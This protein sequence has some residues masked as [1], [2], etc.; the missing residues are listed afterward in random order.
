MT[1]LRKLAVLPPARMKG[2]NVETALKERRVIVADNVK[3]LGGFMER[4]LGLRQLWNTA[5]EKEI[6]F[7]GEDKQHP[8]FLRPELYRPGKHPNGTDQPLKP[9]PELLR[10]ENDLY[11]EFQRC[12]VQ[13]RTESA[14][15]EDWDWDAY[16]L[17]QHHGAPTRLLDWSDGALMALHFA[18]RSKPRNDPSDAIVYAIDPFR[19][20]EYLDTLQ[21]TKRAEKQWKR[22]VRKHPQ[23]EFPEDEPE[24]VYLPASKEDLKEL[25]PPAVPLLL[26]FPHITRRVAA[27]RSRFLVFGTDPSWLANEATKSDSLIQSIGIDGGSCYRIRRELRDSGITESVIFPD[28]DG[29]GREMRQLWLDRQ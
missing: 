13:L 5:D 26:D 18:V 2:A 11:A 16:F 3:T 27:Q 28:L 22:Y 29:L 1:N 17:M 23:D 8:T 25:S 24:R 20:G 6:W 9:I 10:I 21:E 7:R 15:E 14:P 12:A 4:A 19:L